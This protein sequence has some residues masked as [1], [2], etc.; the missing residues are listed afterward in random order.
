MVAFVTLE[1]LTAYEDYSLPMQS[2]YAQVIVLRTYDVSGTPTG[3]VDLR[4]YD[5][6]EVP[7]GLGFVVEARRT[8][9]GPL[10][11]S[12]RASVLTDGSLGDG[13]DGRLLL[14]FDGEDVPLSVPDRVW[15]TV[16]GLTSDGS[17]VA[18]VNIDL[19]VTRTYAAAP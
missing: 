4:P 14:E 8:P 13:R 10:L 17:P 5:P 1:R 15:V 9:A 12:G 2:D 3:Y 6:H 16:Q 7:A 18:L 11:F 19:E